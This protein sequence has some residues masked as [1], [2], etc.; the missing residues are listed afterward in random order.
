MP[1]ARRRW[2]AG[3]RPRRARGSTAADVVEEGARWGR[4]PAR[5]RGSAGPGRRRAARRRGAARPRSCRSRARPARR[6]AV[7]RRPGRSRPAPAG[8]SPRC[9]ASARPGGARSHGPGSGCAVGGAAASSAGPC[10]RRRVEGVRP[11]RRSAARARPRTGVAGRRPS[12]PA[13]GPVERPATVGPPVDHHRF[14]LDVRDVAPS[15]VPAF[16]VLVVG[17]AEEQG[18]RPG[19]RPG[20]RPGGAASQQDTAPR[21]GHRLGQPGPGCVRASGPGQR[22]LPRGS[23]ALPRVRGRWVDS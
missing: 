21:P 1:R 23:G 4:R 5:R 22:A 14:A 13:A 6:P 19:R 2:C 3:P 7:Q 15:D 17:A 20:R 9:R 10:R 18:G 11:R 12:A 16:A 8:W